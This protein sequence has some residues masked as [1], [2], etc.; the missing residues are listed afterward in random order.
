MQPTVEV[1][2][3]E[4]PRLMLSGKKRPGWL[5]PEGTPSVLSVVTR[6]GGRKSKYATPEGQE[7][8]QRA[9]EMYRDMGEV[10]SFAKV[11][12]ALD[13]PKWQIQG[14]AYKYKWNNQIALNAPAKI[15]TVFKATQDRV[16]EQTLKAVERQVELVKLKQ[17]LMTREDP[18]EPGKELPTEDL[19]IYAL[20]ET[21][22]VLL[23][24]LKSLSEALGLKKT[25]KEIESVGDSG[26]GKGPKGGVMVNVIFKG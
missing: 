24:V 13:L 15:P 12:V 17:S 21:G 20:K 6:K 9:F 5:P 22:T 8:I 2:P 4:K 3:P 25:E 7:V 18:A 16:V 14:W 19:T 10:R 26:G 11:G 23:N 1:L